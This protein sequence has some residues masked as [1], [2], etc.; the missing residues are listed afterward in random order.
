MAMN[1]ASMPRGLEEGLNTYFGLAEKD[2]PRQAM[3]IYRS[4]PLDKAY[5]EDA[6][7]IGLGPVQEKAEGVPMALDEGSEGWLY[8][9]KAKTYAMGFPIT[10][11]GLEDHLYGKLGPRYAAELARA[12][13]ETEEIEGVAPLN[14]GFTTWLTGDG[15]ALFSTAHPVHSGA[16]Q[17]NLLATPANMTEAAVE[18]LAIKIRYAKN[19]RGRP[20][21]L[22]VKDIICSPDNIYNAQR[23]FHSPL[24]SGTDHNDINAMMDMGE[25]QGGVKLMTRLADPEAWFIQTS[26]P[27]GMKYRLR[28]AMTKGMDTDKKAGV[29]YY[30]VRGRWVFGVTNWRH[31]YAGQGT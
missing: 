8:R 23:I 1:R 26:C 9:Y 24:R 29:T 19:D 18:E 14:K 20:I 4:E 17:S 30:M 13:R 5:D 10:E 21:H 2:L 31:I 16:A 25:F 22:D 12:Y 27:D 7:E 28:K 11:E 3:N 6:L 15:V